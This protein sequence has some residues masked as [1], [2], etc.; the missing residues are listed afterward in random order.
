VGRGQAL[1]DTLAAACRHAGAEVALGNRVSR[2]VVDNGRVGGVES[3]DERVSASAVVLTSGGFAHNEELLAEYY[4][5]FAAGTGHW[6]PAAETNVGDGLLMS[7][8]IGAAIV[9][10][11]PGITVLTPGLSRERD[12]FPPGWLVYVNRQG[13]RFINE[14]APYTVMSGA[15]QHR[16]CISRGLWRQQASPRAYQGGHC[17]GDCRSARGGPGLRGGRHEHAVAIL[18]GR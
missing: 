3:R 13:K 7:R 18:R 5:G 12:P 16:G 14:T 11:N 9:G 6:S 10:W 1:V 2:L 15:F 4:P 17:P 8:E